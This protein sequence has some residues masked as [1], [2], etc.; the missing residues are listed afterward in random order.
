MNDTLF[1]KL[2]LVAG[3]PILSVLL[4]YILIA[5]GANAQTPEVQQAL[6]ELKQSMAK[7]KQDLAQYS[8]TEQDIISL[9][10][11]EKKEEFFHVR[12]GQDGK[13]EKTNLD[14]AA[15][16]DDERHRRGL[17]ARIVEKK[18]A[19]YKEY[20]DSMRN[21][22][23]QYVPPEKDLLQQ[24]YQKGNPMIGPTKPQDSMTLVFDKQQKR[25]LS[26]NISS[27][28]SDPSDAV[29]LNVQFGTLA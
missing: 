17:K 22:M 27:Y 28:L 24:A 19:E 3:F 29:K 13:P 9:K 7:N 23:Q 25:L 5:R 18:T 6:A 12:L 21:L 16:S 11:E 26:M 2:Q 10:G 8:W 14:P 15:M 20:A 1:R 4:C